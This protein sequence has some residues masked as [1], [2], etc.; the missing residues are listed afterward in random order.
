MSNKPAFAILRFEK[1]RG[2]PAK[3]IEDHHERNK[4]QY[5]SNP[6]IDTSRSRDNFH[7]IKPQQPYNSEI[8]QRILASGC[9]TRKDSVRF[10]DTLITASPEYLSGLSKYELRAF[11]TTACRFLEERIGKE[12]IVSAV[13]HMDEKTPHMHVIFVPLTHDN[14]LC[15]KE[16][17]GNRTKLIQ[18]QDDFFAHMV[19]VFPD[20][21]RGESASVTGRTHIPTR[22]Y[23]EAAHLSRQAD[24]IMELLSGLSPF[25]T[26]KTTEQLIPLLRRFLPRAEQFKTQVK[27]YD[28][29]FKALAS[30]NAQLK[31]DLKNATADTM[32]KRLQDAKL[33]ADYENLSRLVS[34][35]PPEI[36]KEAKRSKERSKEHALSD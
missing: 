20:L 9:R 3:K 11:F 15:A 8:K 2:N 34:R 36:L 26:K 24:R 18:W 21:E 6:D 14:R 27:K 5:A 32:E 7:I 35:I 4:E 1:H 22:V 12:N 17:I 25:N 16:I 28:A 23:K 10:I 30:E 29:A 33:R 31:D 13:V 19:A